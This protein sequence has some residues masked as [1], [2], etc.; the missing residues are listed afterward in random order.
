MIYAQVYSVERVRTHFVNVTTGLVLAESD[1]ELDSFLES[2]SCVR[3]PPT[4]PV[5]SPSRPP[6]PPTTCWTL[7]VA[8]RLL[9][10]PDPDEL[11]SHVAD[12]LDA[13]ALVDDGSGGFGRSVHLVRAILACPT[14]AISRTLD[15]LRVRGGGGGHGAVA[16]GA[17]GGGTGPGA[18]RRRATA[19]PAPGTFVPVEDHHLL[20]S[21]VFVF[22][23]FFLKICL[24]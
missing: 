14:H 1:A 24:C 3:H 11:Y 12:A 22:Y 23:F 20:R 6:P 18:D 16:G 13:S 10:D 4:S 5:N 7:Y 15:R 19:L 17:G 8:R 9:D 21:V 2:P